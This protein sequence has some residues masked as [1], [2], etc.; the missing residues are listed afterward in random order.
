MQDPEA[1]LEKFDL[2]LP[3][4]VSPQRDALLDAGHR[5]LVNHDVFFVSSPEAREELERRPL[6][7]LGTVTDAVSGLR[8]VPGELSPHLVHEER[9][10]YFFD[11]STLAEFRTDP[12][13]YANPRREM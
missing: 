5:V 3:C 11:A 2:E 13:R 12:E 8:F 9:L 10:Y 4:P 6:R 7:Y 1:Y